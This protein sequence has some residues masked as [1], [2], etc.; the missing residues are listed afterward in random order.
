MKLIKKFPKFVKD[1]SYEIE[2]V[3]TYGYSGWYSEEELDEKT[4]KASKNLTVGYF[5]KEKDGFI[6]LAM[7]REA[8]NDDFLPY[9]SPKWIPWGYVTKI[10]RLK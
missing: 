2:W 6:I 4:E 8:I 7:G 5:V 1:A 10:K 3:D 9:N